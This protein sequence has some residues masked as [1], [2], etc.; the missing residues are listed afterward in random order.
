MARRGTL[1]AL[2]AALAGIGGAAGGYVQQ[3]ELKRKRRSEEEAR[4]RQEMLD[5][6]GLQER[7]FMT[8]EQLASQKEQGVRTTGSVVSNAL[9]SALSPRA[10]MLPPPTAQDVSLASQAL[11]TAGRAPQRIV[12]AGG[13]EMFRAETP[14]DREERLG[15][16]EREQKRMERM[17]ER[18]YEQTF[19]ADEARRRREE[20]QEITP[21]QK[22]QL[23]LDEQRLALMQDK[24][25]DTS[26]EA[27][28]PVQAQTKLAAYNA[29]L[30]QIK[31]LRAAV[32]ANPKAVG[33]KNYIP[34]AMID[35]ADPQGSGVR[36]QV[37]GFAGEIRNQRFGGQLTQEESRRSRQ[38]LPDVSQRPEVMLSRLD[39][40]ERFLEQKR[41]GLYSVYRGE[42]R[43]YISSAD[44]ESGGETLS[45]AD[46]LRRGNY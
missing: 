20:R 32:K 41:K 33:L 19:A 5:V 1:T 16:L 4:Q 11:A 29:S 27:K 22:A 24:A 34:G 46:R 45:A 28:L 9:M 17:E 36:A 43:P 6:V 2:Q 35:I 31:S 14:M 42:Y 7:G 44:I 40:A 26:W 30:D 39:E 23:R 25:K 13:Q 21:F 15:R 10:G 38:F 3:E 37:E 12:T 18:Q 8:P